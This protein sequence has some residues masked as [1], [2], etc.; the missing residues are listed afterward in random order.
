MNENAGC[1]RS[2]DIGHQS[3]AGDANM[4]LVVVVVA[5]TARSRVGGVRFEVRFY[6]I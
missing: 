4:L 6:D 1:P 2:T 5:G 3:T